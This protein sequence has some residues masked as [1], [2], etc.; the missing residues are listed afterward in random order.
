MAGV[1][2]RRFDEPDDTWSFGD[3][4]RSDIVAVEGVTVVRSVLQPGWSWLRDI[5]PQAEGLE[6]C[7][8]HHR[9]YVVSGRI[10]YEVV[11]TGDVVEAGP[12]SYLDIEPGHLASVV[13][14]EP[15]VLVDFD[16][17]WPED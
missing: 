16:E 3:A 8:L 4:G 14:D 6:N 7:P 1:Q 12:G 13:G 10:R 9:E 15:C 2:V 5:K 17:R 11:D